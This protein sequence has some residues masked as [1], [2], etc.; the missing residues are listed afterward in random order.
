MSDNVELDDAEKI[1]L[2][3]KNASAESRYMFNAACRSNGQDRG[4]AISKLMRQL[5]EETYGVG[6]AKGIAREFRQRQA[7][8][9]CKG[10]AQQSK[11]MLIKPTTIDHE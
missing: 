6:G 8:K 11:D 10:S 3:I 4:D 9:A 5:A 2:I 1:T 7:R